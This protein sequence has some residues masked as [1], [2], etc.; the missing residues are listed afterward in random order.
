MKNHFVTLCATTCCETSILIYKMFVKVCVVIF[1]LLAT[2]INSEKIHL[3][4]NKH[5]W[6]SR[7]NKYDFF[8]SV[9]RH[10]QGIYTVRFRTRMTHEPFLQLT[11]KYWGPEGENMVFYIIAL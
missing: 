10:R 11:T 3:V 5:G 2:V 8:E 4:I 1:I 6:I 9:A 7:T